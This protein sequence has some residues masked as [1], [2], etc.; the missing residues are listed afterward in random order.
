MSEEIPHT[1]H[2]FAQFGNRKAREERRERLH[3]RERHKLE[4]ARTIA[5][6]F[7]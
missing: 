5:E 1:L 2:T 6:K 7:S 4:S 3:K